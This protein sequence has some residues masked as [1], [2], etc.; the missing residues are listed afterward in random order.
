MKSEHVHIRFPK[1]LKE[2]L[3][4]ACDKNSTNMSDWFRKMAEKYIK[5]SKK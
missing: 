1:E 2:R 5:E 3:M 4:A